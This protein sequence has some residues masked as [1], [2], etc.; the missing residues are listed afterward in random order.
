MSD[1]DLGSM[2]LGAPRR[3]DFRRAREGLRQACGEY[4][5]MGFR[6]PEP[7]ATPG[8][9]G[10]LGRRLPPDAEF[11]LLDGPAVYP[12][13]IGINTIGRLTDN[14]VVIDNPHVSRRHCAIVV[15]AGAG[16]E[17][18]DVA[19]KNGTFLNGARLCRPLPLISGDA[20]AMCGRELIFVCRSGGTPGAPAPW[21]R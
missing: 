7:A 4:T 13:R 11:G 3:D 15:H 1:N 17:L 18:H 5:R 19:S 21:T 9:A 6:L 14:D 2:H 20:I 12:L 10:E 16:S 8:L